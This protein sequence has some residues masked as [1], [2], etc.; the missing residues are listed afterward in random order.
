MSRSLKKTLLLR[1]QLTVSG[2]SGSETDTLQDLLEIYITQQ[3][4]VFIPVSV[5]GQCRTWHLTTLHNVTI[6]MMYTKYSMH[7]CRVN[8]SF[9]RI[10]N[11]DKLCISSDIFTKYPHI[12]VGVF[13]CIIFLPSFLPVTPTP[14][15]ISNLLQLSLLDIRGTA[16]TSLR[17]F[18]APAVHR[19]VILVCMAC[20]SIK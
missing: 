5:I 12:C 4:S 15:L 17:L 6:S 13:S 9:L 19:T 3:L 14:S 16:S 20:C 2:T 11:S 8:K 1:V 10:R 7:C 18:L